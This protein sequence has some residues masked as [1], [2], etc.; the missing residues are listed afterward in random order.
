[1]DSRELFPFAVSL[2]K[3]KVGER[4][5]GNLPHNEPFRLNAVDAINLWTCRATGIRRIIFLF[6]LHSI[7]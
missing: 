7:K 4:K 5:G 1:M 3:E 6:D 2:Q